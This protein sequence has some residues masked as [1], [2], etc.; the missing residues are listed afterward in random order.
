[1]SVGMLGLSMHARLGAVDLSGKVFYFAKVGAGDTIDL[2][3]AGEVAIGTIYEGNVATLP[4]TVQMDNKGKV[5]LAA[6]IAA[7]TRV[8]SDGDG[9]AVDWASSGYAAGILLTGGDAG[10]ICEIKLF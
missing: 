7:G 5:I 4:T 9:K 8:K 6:T 2:C 1:M 10:D 3:G